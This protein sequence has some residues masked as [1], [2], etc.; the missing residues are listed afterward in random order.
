MVEVL[1]DS[2]K[3]TYKAIPVIFLILLI[4]DYIMY[5]LNNIE[6]IAKF[7]KFDALGG[8]LLGLIPQCGIPI[9]FANL[10]S[11]GYITLGMLIAIFISSSDEA[12]IIIGA[13]SGNLALIF[14]IIVIKVIIGICA[15]FFVNLVIKEKRNRIRGCGIDCRCPKC[16]K[17]KNILINSLIHTG[18]I[19]AFLILTV[20]LLNLGIEKIGEDKFYTMLGKDSYLQ[21]IYAALIGIIPSCMSS[22]VLAEGYLKETIGFSSLIAGLAANTGYGILIVFRELPLQKALKILGLILTIS[23]LVGEIFYVFGS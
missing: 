12:L 10:Y 16:T 23:I 5:K 17:G 3:D 7:S 15:G 22:L 9:G 14:K 1:I 20:F 6:L 19:S 4:V 13:E 8:G 11:K 2:I 21:P 18:R